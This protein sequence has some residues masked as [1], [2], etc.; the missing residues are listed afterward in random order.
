MK[1][2]LFLLVATVSGMGFSASLDWTAA[3]GIESRAGVSVNWSVF[4]IGADFAGGTAYIVQ[5]QSNWTQS[6]IVAYLQQNGLVATGENVAYDSATITEEAGLYFV[7]SHPWGENSPS[8]VQGTYYVIVVNGES[9]AVSAAYEH[10][11]DGNISIGAVE[12]PSWSETGTLAGGD[13]PVDPG[14]P[15]PTALALLALGV[16]GVALRRRVR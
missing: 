4:Q 2:F 12:S 1:K 5:A 16:A 15:E 3:S 8:S 7:D 9:F 6:G 14:V 13:T 10:A 11:M